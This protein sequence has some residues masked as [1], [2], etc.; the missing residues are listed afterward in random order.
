MRFPFLMRRNSGHIAGAEIPIIIPA[1]NNPSYCQMMVE[2]LLGLGL[3]RI[4][5]IDN[6]SNSADMLRLLD[7]LESKIK[8]IR[9]SRNAGPKYFARNWFFYLRLPQIFCVTDPDIQFNPHLPRDFLHTLM[10]LTEEHQIGKVGFALNIQD[11]HAFRELTVNFK[12][13]THDIVSWESQFW[14]QQIGSTKAGD[15]V[16]KADIDTTFALYNKKFFNRKKAGFYRAL[17]VAGGFTARH[18]PWYRENGLDLAEERAY[19]AAQKFS[20]YARP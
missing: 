14:Q 15:P 16:Y 3:S 19:A 8:I 5:L 13:Q 4:I 17:R 18:L 20:W 6:C 9:L 11:H 1:F 10:K 7:A 12:G 2:Q